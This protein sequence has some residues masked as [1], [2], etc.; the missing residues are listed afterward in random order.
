MVLLDPS[1]QP[2]VGH[3]GASGEYPENT[4]LAFAKALEQGADA[5]ECDTRLS[6]DGV[7]VVIHDPTLDRTTSGRGPV[8][9][10]DLASLQRLDA[11][12][13]ERV[14]T[15]A[16]ALATFP[17]TEFILEIKDRRVAM[18]ARRVIADQRAERRVLVGGFDRAALT[19]FEPDVPRSASR[20]E[21]ALY[22]AMARVGLAPFRMPYRAF[23]VPERYGPLT[24][25][26]AAFVR[27][28][29]RIGRPVHVWT[30]NDPADG[31]R[32]R[33]LGVSGLITNYPG[34]FRAL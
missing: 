16:E 26:D 31:R 12:R 9:A 8:A 5:L 23:T 3:R 25:V 21:T 33:T 4:L 11:G 22:W 29:R 6:A 13:G 27:L 24:V 17:R 28:A 10:M 15:L 1:A 7:P 14:P 34:R 20:S 18:P 32:L 19:P 2:V 30:V